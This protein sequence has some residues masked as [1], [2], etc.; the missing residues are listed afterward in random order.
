MNTSTTF[1][2]KNAEFL[3]DLTVLKNVILKLLTETNLSYDEIVG[4]DSLI[5][6]RVKRELTAQSILNSQTLII[7]N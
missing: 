6:E 5:A 1:Q 7:K 2:S 3:T 4:P